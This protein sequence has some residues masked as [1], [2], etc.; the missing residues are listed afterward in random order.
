VLYRS[1]KTGYK[2]K[3]IW[4]CYKRES[5]ETDDDDDD[6]DEGFYLK[7]YFSMKTD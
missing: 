5:E 2:E 1:S 4:I 7:A 3:Q 6:D